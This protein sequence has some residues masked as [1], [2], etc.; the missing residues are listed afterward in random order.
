MQPAAIFEKNT[1]SFSNDC[2][3]TIWIVLPG[4]PKPIRDFA[5]K[6]LR[7]IGIAV[8]TESRASKVSSDEI[9]IYDKQSKTTQNH[10]YGL[11][12][13]ATGVAPGPLIQRLIS[14]IPEQGSYR[15]LKTDARCRVIG[16]SCRDD[17]FALGDCA[18]ID[19]LAMHRQDSS[20]IY[21][22]V[23]RKFQKNA[24]NAFR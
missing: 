1:N 8:K 12:V 5:L 6:R 17:I 22:D 4:Y 13:W 14:D 7:D 18:D 11:V 16:G 9:S 23:Q 20:R 21:D 15:T 19:V 10:P 2:V 3:W 24:C